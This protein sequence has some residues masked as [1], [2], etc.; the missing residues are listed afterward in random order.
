MTGQAS[1][2]N[3]I[4]VTLYN[5]ILQVALSMST[6]SLEDGEGRLESFFNS[7]SQDDLQYAAVIQPQNFSL[8][9]GSIDLN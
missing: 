8:S 1:T 9:T 2:P 4:S 7:T 3:A 5:R 6:S